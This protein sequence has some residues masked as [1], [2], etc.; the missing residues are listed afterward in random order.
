M[1]DAETQI[2][3]LEVTCQ[4]FI[5]K[6]TIKAEKEA[7]A[8]IIQKASL[9][10]GSLNQ[11]SSAQNSLVSVVA[12]MQKQNSTIFIYNLPSSKQISRFRN[13]N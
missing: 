8:A 10:R 6:N 1:E 4:L 12:S 7:N 3:N 13:E 5:K 2:D 9:L 11:D